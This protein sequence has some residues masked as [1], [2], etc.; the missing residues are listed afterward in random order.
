MRFGLLALASAAALFTV[1]AHAATVFSDDF[2]SD[3]AGLGLTSLKNFTVL[4]SD[5]DPVSKTVDVVSPATAPSFGMTVSSNVVDLDGTPGPAFMYSNDTFKYKKGD[6]ITL[7]FDLGGAQRGSVSDEFQALFLLD[8]LQKVTSIGYTNL[9]GNDLVAGPVWV[10]GSDIEA[11]FAGTEPMEKRSIFF[12]AAQDGYFKF[13]FATTSADN[14]GTLLD[15][16]ILDITPGAV[17]E[18][19]TWAMM[20]AGFGAVGMGMRRRRASAKVSFA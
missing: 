7:T 3:Q 20:I 9:D 14:V 18:S 15:N 6:T 11:F 8:S 19:S 10:Y 12:T 1:P 13:A 4:Q 17:P 5:S 16:V 2:E